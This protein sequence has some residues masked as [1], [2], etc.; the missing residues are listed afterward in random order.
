MKAAMICATVTLLAA[1][2]YAQTERGYITGVGGFAAAPDT[3]SGDV[4]GE[5]GVRVA[6]HLLV[7]GDIGQ[8][9]NLQPSDAQ[10]A[11]DSTTTTVGF[12]YRF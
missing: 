10:P 9:H 5:V 7:F 12:G 2:L 4:L 11:V 8:F 1:A 3:T 6:P